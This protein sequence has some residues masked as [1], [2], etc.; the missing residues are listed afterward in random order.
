MRYILA[1]KSPRRRELL[2]ELVE[3]FE[4]IT[5][6]VDE[7]LPEGIHPRDGVE[8]LAV[9]KGEVIVIRALSP[10]SF[11][12]CDFATSTIFSGATSFPKSITSKL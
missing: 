5:A 11:I 4:I 3:S 1:S 7:T 9:R 12:S 10:T 8:I 6:E 2:S